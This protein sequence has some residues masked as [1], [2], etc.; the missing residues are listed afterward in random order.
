MKTWHLAIALA[1]L[2]LSGTTALA[3]PAAGNILLS[4]GP[5][6]LEADG[7]RIPATRGQEI[8]AGQKLLTGNGG[9]LHVR[10]KDGGLVAIRPNS[11]LEVQVFE[12]DPANPT[13][14]KVRYTLRHGVARSV[15]GAIGEANKEAFRFNTPVAAIGVRGTDFVAFADAT[16]TRVSIKSGAIVVAALGDGCAAEGFGACLDRSITLRAG[17]NTG[18]VEI[19]H[20]D[21]TPRLLQ[22]KHYQIPDRVSPP[23]ASEPVAVLQEN[24]RTEAVSEKTKQIAAIT[25]PTTP[26]VAPTTPTDTG[27]NDVYWGRWK[28]DLAGVSG[29]TA[30]E[31]LAA[32]KKIRV[33]SNLFGLGVTEMP[34]RLPDNWKAQ[35]NLTGGDAYVLSGGVYS[36]ATLGSGTLTIDTAARAFSANASVTEGLNTHAIN[37]A[38]TV[39]TSG[40]L[41]SDATRSN[42]TFTGVVHANLNTVG[43]VFTRSLDDGRALTGT[44]VWHR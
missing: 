4:A 21:K 2:L 41:L 35:F 12:Y 31:L 26:T 30:S 33:V 7:K 3:G 38:G 40:Y 5:A 9:H 24:S 14:G 19:N 17:D 6:W 15:T 11:E 34:S 28:A 32:Q 42:S 23:L 25:A 37:A 20:N 39:N 36:A 27:L 10:M 43:S 8:E 44:M 29:S 22:D 1:S 16:A 13:G 18:H